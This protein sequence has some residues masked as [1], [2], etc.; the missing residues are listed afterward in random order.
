MLARD[1]NTTLV[2]LRQFSEVLAKDIA[3][4]LSISSLMYNNQNELIYQ[5]DRK[6]N[7]SSNVKDILHVLRKR[8]NKAV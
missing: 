2:K 1:P 7:L 3:T 5:I 6:L 8:G 4:K